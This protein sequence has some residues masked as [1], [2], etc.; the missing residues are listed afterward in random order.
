MNDSQ[1]CLANRFCGQSR[2]RLL[3][4]LFC[5]SG[6]LGYWH[7]KESMPIAL[8]FHIS[9]LLSPSFPFL[10]SHGTTFHSSFLFPSS[11]L[12]GLLFVRISFILIYHLFLLLVC[13]PLAIF[14]LWT[15]SLIPSSF[16]TKECL[17]SL[18]LSERHP[19][20]GC[21]KIPLSFILLP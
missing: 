5:L 16:P 8:M 11:C 10:R 6:L 19:V 13:D 21:Q 17:P 18:P 1:Q 20:C 15:S 7:Q 4:L 3:F 12:V 14:L 2:K 9:C